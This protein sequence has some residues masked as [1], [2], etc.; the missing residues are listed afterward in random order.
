MP[1]IIYLTLAWAL[2]IGLYIA[3]YFSARYRQR[4]KQHSI[5]NAS[6]TL[7]QENIWI[8]YEPGHGGLFPISNFKSPI[9]CP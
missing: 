7:V 8:N 1:A 2:I 6:G 5:T 4:Q 9:T 3:A